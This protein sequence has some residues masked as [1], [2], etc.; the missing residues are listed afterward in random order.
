MFA[1]WRQQSV[2]IS[3]LRTRLTPAF[4]LSTDEG[5][6]IAIAI[7]RQ[8]FSGRF[9]KDVESRYVRIRAD[10]VSHTNI[11]D[12][13]AFITAITKQPLLRDAAPDGIRLPQPILLHDIMSPFTSIDRFRR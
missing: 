1:L 10:N 3:E 5:G 8:Y 12:G 2:L 4:S 6:P 13:V 9:I 11:P 7:D